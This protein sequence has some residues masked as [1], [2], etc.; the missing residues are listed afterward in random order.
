ML[1]GRP[2]AL[3]P[4]SNRAYPPVK[5]ILRNWYWKYVLSCSFE[6]EDPVASSVVLLLALAKLAETVSFLNGELASPKE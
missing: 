2:E 5:Y 6:F 4:C 3:K 1:G